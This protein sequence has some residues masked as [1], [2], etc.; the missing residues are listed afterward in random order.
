MVKFVQSYNTLLA[1]EGQRL[2]AEDILDSFICINKISEVMLS[3]YPHRK[4][5]FIE[6]ICRI[7]KFSG[8]Q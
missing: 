7:M 3:S 5:I 1:I 8:L 4:K 2:K 6:N